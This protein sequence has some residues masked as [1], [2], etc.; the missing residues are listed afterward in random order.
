M[1]A[2]TN[3]NIERNHRRPMLGSG[4]KKMQ[5]M[6]FELQHYEFVRATIFS[7]AS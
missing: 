3:I 2:R 7:F 4:S 1:H 6:A 5:A